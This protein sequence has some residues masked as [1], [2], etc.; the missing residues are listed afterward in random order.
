MGK[1][2]EEKLSSS[3]PEVLKNQSHKGLAENPS[4]SGLKIRLKLPKKIEELIVEEPNK[5]EPAPVE[6]PQGKLNEA[7]KGFHKGIQT[8]NAVP[9]KVDEMGVTEKGKESENAKLPMGKG[10]GKT[11]K[12]PKKNINKMPVAQD[13]SISL[14]KREIKED[15]YAF[16]QRKRESRKLL[17]RAK[18][19]QETLDVRVYLFFFIVIL[20][21]LFSIFHFV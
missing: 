4:G 14:T 8:S 6:K 19:V 21:I 17:K 16:T 13:A 9:S 15:F 7:K 11:P 12:P 10:K 1:N 2:S 18:N 5:H 20:R 3:T